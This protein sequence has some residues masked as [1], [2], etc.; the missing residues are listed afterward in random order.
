MLNKIDV[1]G[2]DFHKLKDIAKAGTEEC[3]CLNNSEI[4]TFYRQRSK[5][6]LGFMKRFNW[7]RNKQPRQTAGFN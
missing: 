2:D 5:T 1:Q 4:C 3:K 7:M 6:T